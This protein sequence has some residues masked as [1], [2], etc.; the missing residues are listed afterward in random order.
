MKYLVG[1]SLIVVIVVSFIGPLY[2][3]STFS[4]VFGDNNPIQK[5]DI[6]LSLDI[7]DAEFQENSYKL[8]STSNI[9]KKLDKLEE[10]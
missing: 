7:Q 6:S 2:I 1:T 10:A 3:F 9:I 8:F 5:A 4:S